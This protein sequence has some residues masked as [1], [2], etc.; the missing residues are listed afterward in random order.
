MDCSRPDSS[1]QGILQAVD[2]HFL[3]QGIFQTQGSNLHLLRCRQILYHEPPGKPWAAY[4]KVK[5]GPCVSPGKTCFPNC[6]I[7]KHILGHCPSLLFCEENEGL[8]S[9]HDRCCLLHVHEEV[10][11]LQHRPI[12]TAV[13]ETRRVW[14]L[15]KTSTD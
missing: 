15:I 11:Y 6:L 13:R 8:N 14:S 2:G 1:V 10:L 12:A 7:N 3:L 5:Q 4:S 9:E